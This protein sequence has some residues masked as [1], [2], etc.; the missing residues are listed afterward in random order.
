MNEFQIIPKDTNLGRSLY[1]MH[2]LWASI[3]DC[4]QRTN[5]DTKA[6]NGIDFDKLA[7]CIHLLWNALHERHKVSFKSVYH[8]AQGVHGPGPALRERKYLS[9]IHALDVISH[10]QESLKDIKNPDIYLFS[11]EKGEWRGGYKYNVKP[12]RE[13]AYF[14]IHLSG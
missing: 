7:H 6:W 3:L 10:I 8:S 9:P 12:G 11:L 5:E 14:P 2:A 13:R 4:W 1:G